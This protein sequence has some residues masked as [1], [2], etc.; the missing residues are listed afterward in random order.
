[1]K[2]KVPRPRHPSARLLYAASETEADT[3]CPT[4]F[5]AP[6]PFLFIQKGRRTILVMGD[7][8]MDRA[9]RETQV[10][11]VMSWSRLA[12]PPEMNGKDSR[13]LTRVPKQLEI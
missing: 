9:R 10:D 4:G 11:R 13:C 2:K 7:L 5:F 3:V 12:A 1:M 6:D 8:Q